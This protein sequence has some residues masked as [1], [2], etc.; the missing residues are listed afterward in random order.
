MPV[1]D[2]SNFNL[3]QTN[4]SKAYWC[5]YENEK[6]QTVFESAKSKIHGYNQNKSFLSSSDSF[7]QS[8][9]EI[10]WFDSMFNEGGLKIGGDKKRPITLLITG[11]PGSGKTT[12]ALELC[13][14]V[15]LYHDLWSLY[16][17][18]ESETGALNEKIEAFGIKDNFSVQL[19]GDKFPWHVKSTSSKGYTTLFGRENVEKKKGFNEITKEAIEKVITWLK[20][21]NKD[22]AG[23]QLRNPN[24]KDKEIQSPPIVVFDSLNM[25][26]EPPNVRNPA[27]ATIKL[28][29]ASTKLLI[30]V[31]ANTKENNDYLNWKIA[32]DNIIH[33]DYNLLTLDET[34]MRDYYTRSIEVV[35]A[36]YQGHKWGKHQMKIYGSFDQENKK[37]GIDD[38]IMRRSHPY[39]EEGGIFVFPSIHSF[40]SSYKK[41]ASDSK[42]FKKNASKNLSRDKDSEGFVKTPCTGLNKL[43]KG[44]PKGRCTALMGVRGGHKSHLAYL[45]ILEQIISGYLS[46]QKDKAGIIIS[47]RDDEELTKDHL[48]KILMENIKIGKYDEHPEY[49]PKGDIKEIEKA[50]KDLVKKLQENN[51][52][53]ILYFSP[54]YITSDEFFHRMFMSIFKLRSGGK[55][56]TKDM[57]ISA[58]F[59]S[60]DQ[61]AARFPL[62]AHQPIFI[63]AMIHCLYGENVTSIFIGVNEPGQPEAQY[64][65]LPMADLI[66]NFKREKIT[67]S[68][69]YS[70]HSKDA[71]PSKKREEK[72]EEVVLEI[73]RF[74][75]GKKAGNRGLLELVYSDESNE[76][77]EP[78]KKTRL[79]SAPGLHF[80]GWEE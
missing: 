38:S 79:K 57:E 62:C 24:D 59:N 19:Y 1:N 72:R 30:V 68:E 16:I 58:M 20:D 27:E 6:N 4:I 74:A 47:L 37:L 43:I 65:L 2:K 9:N 53:E 66:L 52:L 54:G 5:I 22:K 76:P 78:K 63:P 45:H 56:S 15:A 73:S 69:Y 13:N 14:R 49:S 26:E 12:L 7:R 32:C 60:L 18:T 10:S 17:S 44:F 23:L 77:N 71:V 64:G 41:I 36:R 25:I 11:P 55:N 33:L 42:E 50:A 39:R 40:L 35:K 28:I 67:E 3:I 61:L 51:L 70:I 21:S 34:S 80:T 8:E 75:G 48:V 31:L 29:S 46:K